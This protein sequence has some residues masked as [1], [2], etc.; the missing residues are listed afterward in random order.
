LHDAIASE[1]QGTP[2]VGVMTENFVSAAELMSQVLGLPEYEF[3]VIEHPVSS[4]DDQGLRARAQHTVD[5]LQ[6][7]VIDPSS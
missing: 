4:A 6:R 5:A 1:R 7:L 3:A 2:A